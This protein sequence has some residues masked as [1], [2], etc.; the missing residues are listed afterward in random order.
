MTS[1]QGLQENPGEGE[2]TSGWFANS[3]PFLLAWFSLYFIE[4]VWHSEGWLAKGTYYFSEGNVY[5][6]AELQ[7]HYASEGAKLY[8][9]IVILPYKGGVLSYNTWTYGKK[10]RDLFHHFSVAMQHNLH[11]PLYL[12]KSGMSSEKI[13][14]NNQ[15]WWWWCWL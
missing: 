12:E 10:Q 15:M 13:N 9:I 6:C 3:F 11:A 2:H 8:K 14:W 4:F 1:L 7:Y 5:E